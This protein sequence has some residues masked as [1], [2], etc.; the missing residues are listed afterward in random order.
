MTTRKIVALAISLAV[1]V[2]LIMFGSGKDTPIIEEKVGP[3]VQT[4]PPDGYKM[5]D[6]VYKITC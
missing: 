2:P 5:C 6:G 4:L 1:F 3:S